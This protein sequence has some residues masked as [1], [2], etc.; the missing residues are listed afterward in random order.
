MDN[1]Q[2]SG[3][4]ILVV[5]DH[6]PNIELLESI[7]GGSGYGNLRSTTD[8]RE[9]IL[10]FMEF[11]PDLAIVDLRM[12][13]IDGYALIAQFRSLTP[14]GSYLPVLVLTADNSR[15]A[16]QK[17]LAIG[18]N[19]FVIKPFDASEV[20]LRVHNLLH[21]R[22]LYRQILGQN[23][24]LD[25]R[26][27]E[28]TREVEESKLDI[29]LRLAVA[30]E[31]RDDATGAHTRRVGS[32][33]GLLAQTLGL[34]DSETRLIQ[35]TAPVHDIGKIGIP[36]HILLKRGKLTREEFE[37]IKSHVLIGGKILSRGKSPLLQ[38]AESIALYHHERWDGAGYCGGLAAEWIPLPARIVAVADA[39]DALT[40]ERPYKPAW[41]PAEAM[42]EIR[43]QRN[44]RYDA[45]VVDALQKLISNGQIMVDQTARGSAPN[46][47]WAEN[48]FPSSVAC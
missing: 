11:E 24:L 23:R 1:R 4:R 28:R 33:S 10:L 3:S 45:R 5:D 12:P 15:E 14:A 25:E 42:A 30:A 37:T 9:A 22:M 47:R 36:D 21:T 29:L 19:D 41:T 31:Y 40:H 27:R 38:M 35:L 13:Q 16:K 17:A 26:V 46:G 34:S 20:L 6:L 18:A 44:R 43:R 48:A 2:I 39:F 8:A 32:M 7:L